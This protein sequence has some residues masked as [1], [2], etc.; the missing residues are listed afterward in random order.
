MYKY[1]YICIK[2]I[3]SSFRT[4]QKRKRTTSGI[5]D[6]AKISLYVS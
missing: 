6:E 5:S 4:I 3:A 1:Q 2:K